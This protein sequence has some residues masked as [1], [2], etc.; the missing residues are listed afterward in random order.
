[1]PENKKNIVLAADH[2]GVGLKSQVIGHLV[3]KGYNCIDLGPYDIEKKVDY[4]DYANQLA[5]IV[6]SGSAQKGI[7]IC[8][9]GV[10]MSIVANKHKNIRAALVHNIETS[11]KSREHNDSNVLCL[12]AWI[13]PVDISIQIVDSWLNEPFG[14]GRHVKR[15]E[16][17]VPHDKQKI[18]FTNGIF[19]M[20]HTGHIELLRFAKS[21]GGKLIVG[22]NSDRATRMIKGD[23]R[24]VN[25]ENDRKAVLESVSF[26]DE[27]IVF[28]DA[29]PTA[30]VRE[31]MPNIVVKGGEWTAEEV[32][33]RD[34]IPGGVEVKIFP[35]VPNYSTT[36]TLKKIK[37]LKTW[38]KETN[39]RK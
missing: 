31:I 29:E 7:L 21:L 30:L 11:T 9:T 39:S 4:V 13:T 19:D 35:L 32:R 12:G 14:E 8:G 15:I 23:A 27:V 1:M 18:V 5:H 37:E 6:E 20:L 38:E 24:P 33:K 34:K 26:V 16:K 36:S 10:G 25:N 22:I 17:I 2:N 3:E 28:D